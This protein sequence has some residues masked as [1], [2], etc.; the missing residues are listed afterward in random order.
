MR[1]AQEARAARRPQEVDDLTLVD[2]LKR[3]L[4]A[5]GWLVVAGVMLWVVWAKNL[6]DGY[7]ERWRNAVYANAQVVSVRSEE[8]WR[9]RGGS[10]QVRIST[11][12]FDG[13]QGEIYGDYRI[14]EVLP[15]R[16]L[17]GND[18]GCYSGNVERVRSK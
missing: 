18:Y 3:K 6:V 1:G 9:R 4:L 8:R 14:G 12:E 10:H 5:G 15:V 2:R 17:P 7:N 11:I 16:Y 13:R